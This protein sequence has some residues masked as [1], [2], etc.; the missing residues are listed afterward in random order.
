MQFI[1]CLC[2][3]R[4]IRVVSVVKGGIIKEAVLQTE[5]IWCNCIHGEV[6]PSWRSIF[7]LAAEE[8]IHRWAGS[9]FP[10]HA[11][12]MTGSC[13]TSKYVLISPNPKQKCF[14]LICVLIDIYT[15]ANHGN[16]STLVRVYVEG[17]RKCRLHNIMRFVFL[18][19]VNSVCNV[20]GY[21]KTTATKN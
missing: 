7:V 13:G 9:A 15:V 11:L 2:V 3:W 10:V 18:V 20:M 16:T 14:K 19:I 5:S 17:S 4:Y 21:L 1:I 8:T 6:Y 12:Q